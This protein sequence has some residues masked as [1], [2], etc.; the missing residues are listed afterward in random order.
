VSHDRLLLKASFRSPLDRAPTL[1]VDGRGQP[2]TRTDSLGW[3]WAFDRTGLEPGREYQLALEDASGRALSEPWP[4]RTFPDPSSRPSRFRILAYT[5]AGG[6]DA[7]RIPG[8][9]DPFWVPVPIR[10]RLLEAGLAWRPDAV[11]AIGDHVYW[12]LRSP[13]SA[14]MLGLAPEGR[15]IVDAFERSIPVLGT[16]NE[17]KL[18]RVVRPQ[19]ADLY[20]TMFRSTPTFFVQDD[21]DYFEN[22]YAGPDLI[23]FPPDD[24]MLRMARATQ[25]MYYPEFL[26]DRGRP[27]T[28]PSGGAPDRPPGVSESFGTV[29]YGSLAELML[30]DCR[31][32]MTLTGADATFVPPEVEAWLAGR[33]AAGEARHVVNVPSVPPGWS[34]GKWGEWYPDRLSESGHLAT[35]RPKYMWQAGWLAQHDRLL[36]AASRRDGIP[37]FLSGDLHAIG[38]GRIHSTDRIDLSHNPVTSV[39]TGPVST[40]PLG[41]P[42][43]FR[44]TPAL[45]P[46]ELT[47]DEGLAPLERNG[48]SVVDFTWDRVEVRFFSWRMGEP[49]SH[50]DGLRPFHELTVEPLR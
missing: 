44:G 16:A 5:C 2:G 22:D 39:L 34:A 35:D 25:W 40:G 47:V 1:R 33:L 12:D 21:H 38:H 18:Q 20:G 50:L 8:T 9:S 14:E 46:S 10:H 26:P 13:H 11:V 3:C 30:Y 37:L 23:T 45:V 48:F 42:S 6:H 17:G 29:R 24:F 28:L 19:I 7:A 15:R 31:R 43:A 41:W 49:V 32:F 27:V 36:E 4:L